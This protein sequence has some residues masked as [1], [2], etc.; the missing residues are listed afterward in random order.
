MSYRLQKPHKTDRERVNFICVYNHQN[1]L[2]IT[3]GTDT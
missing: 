2:L 1:G 3:E